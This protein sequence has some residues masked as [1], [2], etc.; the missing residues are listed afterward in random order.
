MKTRLQQQEQVQEQQEQ[1]PAELIS[2]FDND[3]QLVTEF[4][5]TGYTQEELLGSTITHPTRYDP[6]VTLDT[7][8]VAGFYINNPNEEKYMDN[9]R[10]YKN[11]TNRFF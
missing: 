10:L 2:K 5:E 8:H 11:R 7:G 9:S 3:K 1:I 6:I 4:L